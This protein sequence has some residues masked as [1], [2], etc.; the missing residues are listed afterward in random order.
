MSYLIVT[1]GLVKYSKEMLV[2]PD[3][4]DYND[5]IAHLVAVKIYESSLQLLPDMEDQRTAEGYLP[6]EAK[7]FVDANNGGMSLRLKDGVYE[8]PEKVGIIEVRQCRYKNNKDKSWKL[9]TE[10]YPCDCDFVTCGCEF[11]TVARFSERKEK[12][13]TIK[14]KD[15]NEAPEKKKREIYEPALRLQL[16]LGEKASYWVEASFEEELMKYKHFHLRDGLYFIYG[17]KNPNTITVIK[18]LRGYETTMVHSPQVI[19]DFHYTISIDDLASIIH[20][21]VGGDYKSIKNILSGVAIACDSPI[22]EVLTII[23]NEIE[24]NREN[25]ELQRAWNILFKVD[26]TVQPESGANG[27]RSFLEQPE[28]KEAPSEELIDLIGKFDDWRQKGAWWK[29]TDYRHPRT[30]GRYTNRINGDV[31]IEETKDIKQ[32]VQMF[33]KE[34]KIES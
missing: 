13:E 33:F 32:L 4:N 14:L 7:K 22:R 2:K 21:T 26:Q 12:P 18:T 19:I 23:Q 28:K 16:A 27:Y 5:S 3:F 20:A 9:V 17:L 34:M 15:M 30:V 11:R 1:N 24:G 6:I 10:E 31:P 8:V 29:S 25:D